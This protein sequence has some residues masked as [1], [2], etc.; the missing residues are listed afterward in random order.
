VFVQVQ[1]PPFL[2]T[3]A[4]GHHVG[5]LNSRKKLGRLKSPSFRNINASMYIFAIRVNG[6]ILDEVHYKLFN[7]FHP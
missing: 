3:L 6:K 7:S 5:E 1:H 2:V 4:F